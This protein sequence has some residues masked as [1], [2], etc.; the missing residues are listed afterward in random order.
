MPVHRITKLGI[1]NAYLVEEDD[2][3]TLVDTLVSKSADRLLTAARGLGRPIAR[4]VVTHGHGDHIGSL[5]ALRPQV[6][7]AEVAWSAREGR[8]IGQDFALEPGERGTPR[9]SLFPKV[10]TAADRT[11]APGDRIGSLEVVAA[12]GHTPGQIALLDVRDRTL[13][14]ADAM[15]TVG[16]SPR[17]TSSPRGSLPFPFPALLATDRDAARATGRALAALS[18]ARI[19]PGHGPVVELHGGELD[20]ALER[21]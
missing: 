12:P 11:V 14:C 16:G 21:A 19:A 6:P 1:V 4:V 2:G 18:P 15:H 17:V 9:P 5:D 8:L 13:Y 7:Q 20:A 3:L 10:A